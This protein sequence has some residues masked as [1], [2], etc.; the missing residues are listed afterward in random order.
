[1]T[2]SDLFPKKPSLARPGWCKARMRALAPIPGLMAKLEQ[3]LA[4]QKERAEKTARSLVHAAARK[5]AQHEA[6]ESKKKR[7]LAAGEDDSDFDS[8]GTRSR[9]HAEAELAKRKKRS[10]KCKVRL[11]RPCAAA[12][13]LPAS[14]SPL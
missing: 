12:S 3:E 14:P 11:T 13:C 9:R 5:K 10:H 8:P 2:F 6:K 1:M 7:K 4:K